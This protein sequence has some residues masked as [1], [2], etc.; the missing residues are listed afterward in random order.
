MTMQPRAARGSVCVWVR[1][2]RTRR[3]GPVRPV[4]P[5]AS[6]LTPLPPGHSTACTC[7]QDRRTAGARTHTV[8]HP[9]MAQG[10]LFTTR[11]SA[12]GA[13]S[14]TRLGWGSPTGPA[15]AAAPAAPLGPAM[16]CFR[17]SLAF[18]TMSSSPPPSLCLDFLCCVQR[19]RATPRAGPQAGGRQGGVLHRP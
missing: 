8:T 10:A 19:R 2:R 18:F 13:D 6:Q 1:G 15:A 3:E 17:N 16:A 7:A 12:T 4:R 9:S 11:R 14:L 5:P